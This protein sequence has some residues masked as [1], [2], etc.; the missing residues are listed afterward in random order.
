MNASLVCCREVLARFGAD[1]RLPVIAELTLYVLID[2]YDMNSPFG[3]LLTSRI[4]R[5]SILSHLRLFKPVLCRCVQHQHCRG[6]IVRG[7]GVIVAALPAPPLP[8]PTPLSTPM[9]R[10]QSDRIAAAKEEVGRRVEAAVMRRGSR[11][12]SLG[13][14]R[15]RVEERRPELREAALI[16]PVGWRN[17]SNRKS[18]GGGG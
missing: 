4:V 5:H 11:Y 10:T 12:G 9:R 17:L 1:P 14:T 6:A 8:R 7:R 13:D 3:I 16:W 18:D 2:F 15:L